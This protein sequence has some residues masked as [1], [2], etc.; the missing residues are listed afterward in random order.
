MGGSKS[1]PSKYSI[2]MIENDGNVIF[3]TEQKINYTFSPDKKLREIE[4]WK[5]M[6]NIKVGYDAN[7]D[8]MII[9]KFTDNHLKYEILYDHEYGYKVIKNKKLIGIIPSI[10]F[11]LTET[12][13]YK[14]WQ[15]YRVDGIY[16]FIYELVDVYPILRQVNNIQRHIPDESKN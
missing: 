13:K 12:E 7:T 3:D 9:T 14:E 15:F 8:E 16:E 2:Y 6:Y 10:G 1:K 5:Y 4:L 11:F